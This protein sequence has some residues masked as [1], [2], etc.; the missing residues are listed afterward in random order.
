ME[1]KQ[2]CSSK[3]IPGA[4]NFAKEK[5]FTKSSDVALR[6]CELLRAS[7]ASTDEILAL[8]SDDD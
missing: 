4:G 6:A 3:D 2:L 8:F 5:L 7:G 1:F